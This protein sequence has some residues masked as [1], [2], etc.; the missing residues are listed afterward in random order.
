MPMLAE[1]RGQISQ[2]WYFKQ[3]SSSTNLSKGVFFFE[4]SYGA[5]HPA[6]VPRA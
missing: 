5:G 1:R 3:K 2:Q 4:N 6:A